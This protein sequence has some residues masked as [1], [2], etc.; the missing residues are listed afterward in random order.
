MLGTSLKRPE[1]ACA[2]VCWLVA[3]LLLVSARAWGT[4]REVPGQYPTIQ[5]AIDDC[6]PGDTVLLDSGVYRG[7]GNRDIELRGLDIV[8][9]SRFGLEQ[10]I[11][12]CEDAGRGFNICQQETPAARI[13][14]ITIWR[15]YASSHGG[16]GI[17]C[18]AAAPTIADCKVIECETSSS[19]GGIILV[20]FDGV[21]ERCSI[22]K[23][24]AD[25]GG[26][27]E[28]SSG[29]GEVIDCLITGNLAVRGGGVYLEG[30]PPIPLVGCTVAANLGTYGGGIR[31]YMLELERCI[32]WGN[33]AWLDGDEIYCG[34]GE[35][36]CCAIDSSGVDCSTTATYDPDCLFTNPLFCQPW[37]CGWTAHGNWW[38]DASSPCLPEH[39]PCGELIGA[40]GEGCGFVRVQ[41]TTWGG[42]KALFLSTPA[43]GASPL[44]P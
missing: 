33:C 13:E 1:R 29:T 14:G 9:K 36:R 23:C 38:L 34:R 5:A 43:S 28:V 44:G 19:G 21:L 22:V 39:S 7:V 40:L 4:V 11:I 27:L 26:G 18:A 25:R 37:Q 30:S 8:V 41:P 3:A 35:F 17:R 24:N 20:A 42:V 12:D 2:Q 32:V 16:G 15:G 10:T 31:A 6:A